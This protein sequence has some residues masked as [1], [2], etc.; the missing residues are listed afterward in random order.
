M[1]IALLISPECS[2]LCHAVLNNPYKACLNKPAKLSLINPSRLS[3]RGIIVDTLWETTTGHFVS[4]NLG[5]DNIDV[6][7]V[8]QMFKE[9]EAEQLVNKLPEKY[10]D[11]TD[12]EEAF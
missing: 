3:I 5:N 8:K 11:V 1:K 9:L 2:D 6:G 12:R 7:R 4:I 10:I